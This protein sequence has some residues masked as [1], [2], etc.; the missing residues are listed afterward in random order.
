MPQYGKHKGFIIK[1]CGSDVIA[2]MISGEKVRDITF[3]ADKFP[4]VGFKLYETLVARL[5]IRVNAPAKQPVF[6]LLSL[7]VDGQT[8]AGLLKK[9]VHFY[10]FSFHSSN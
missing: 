6:G 4:L 8:T 2:I 9:D 7:K 1:R 3:I 5:V 10:V